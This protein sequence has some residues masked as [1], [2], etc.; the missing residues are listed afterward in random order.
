MFQKIEQGKIKGLLLFGS[1]PIVSSPN[2]ALIRRALEKLELFVVVDLFQTE[3]AQYA[4]WLLPSAS[5]LETEGTLTNL[6]GRVFHRPMALPLPGEC[7]TDI[8]IMCEL[9]EHLG[10]GAYFKYETVEE[11]FDELCLASKG[12][13][14]DYSAMNYTKLKERKGLF[15]PCTDEGDAGIELMFTDGFYHPDK[16]AVIKP[17]EPKYPAEPTTMEYPY[18]LTT[19]RLGNH[20][21]SGSQTRRTMALNKKAPVP[22]AEIH[23]W[24][25]KKIGLKLHEQIKLSSRRGS[26]L[27]HVKITESIHP[28]V[29]FVPFHWGDELSIN[30]LTIDQLDPT[31]RM[32]EFKL[33]AVQVEAQ[34]TR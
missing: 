19:G 15:W 29:I 1:N 18:V 26:I 12:G 23:P 7:K 33:C 4:E 17:I 11:I 22:L 21:L 14:A 9:A 6:E 25:A 31:S 30:Q 28:R 16:K 34:N 24:L 5:F 27:L 13:K 3:T 10:K 20:Y 8:E 2:S 32:P